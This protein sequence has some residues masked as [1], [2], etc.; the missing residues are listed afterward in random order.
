MTSVLTSSNR[1]LSSRARISRMRSSR[2]GIPG[3]SLR[4][5]RSLRFMVSDDTQAQHESRRCGDLAWGLMCREQKDSVEGGQMLERNR[6]GWI[7]RLARRNSPVF[8]LVERRQLLAAHVAGDSTIYATNQ[9][10]VDAAAPGGAV[11]VDPGNY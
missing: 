9:A 1:P 10:A 3:A 4:D 7:T 5:L 8:E 2:P 6:Q 11:T